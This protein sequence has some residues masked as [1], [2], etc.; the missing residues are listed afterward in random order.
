M[1]GWYITWLYGGLGQS[2]AR[3]RSGGIS[4]GR[5]QRS[6][7]LCPVPGVS[8]GGFMEAG[9][10]D[11]S[12]ILICFPKYKLLALSCKQQKQ[13]AQRQTCKCTSTSGPRPAPFA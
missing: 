3:L 1:L 10:R 9:A 5:E 13:N 6:E 7:S 4:G 11:D 12:L 2:C 8:F